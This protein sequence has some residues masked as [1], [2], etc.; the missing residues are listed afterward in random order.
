MPKVSIRAVTIGSYVIMLGFSA[1]LIIHL[2]WLN[3]YV[4]LGLNVLV[5]GSAAVFIDRRFKAGLAKVNR[6]AKSL[7]QGDLT[8]AIDTRDGD[9]FAEVATSLNHAVE[10]LRRTVRNIEKAADTLDSFTDAS[11]KRAKKGAAINDAQREKIDSIATAIEEMTTTV[12][13]LSEDVQAI[14]EEA[15]KID[16]S[17]RQSQQELTDMMSELDE[18]VSSIKVSAEMFDKVEH[19]ASQIEHF[20]SVITDVAEQTNLLALN[21]AIEAARAGEQGRGFAVVADEVRQLAS[22]TQA[23][24]SE[25]NDMTKELFRSL[26]QSS[27][28]SDRTE[29]LA[30]SA[31][32]Q[33]SD[34]SQSIEGVLDN[35]ST[36]SDRINS[37]ASAIEQQRTVSTD[38][39]ANIN[40]LT[41]S[42]AEAA[43][44]SEENKQD[45][46]KISDLSESLNQDLDELQLR[47]K[48][49]VLE[50]EK[51]HAS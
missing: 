3:E 19:S 6:F 17:S 23:S 50:A 33:A 35:F 38:I 7:A 14:S 21:A 1:S 47:S 15:G 5:A 37:L 26:K 42:G 51:Q 13:S 16:S 31:S 49:P 43:E 45:M 46:V 30:Q 10:K 20:L 25:I 34:T 39:A 9:E 24:A 18:L 36:I 4:V 27:E 28:L 40:R 22:R 48:K 12:G 41:E 44:I 8:A 29:K 11:E 32:S 2:P